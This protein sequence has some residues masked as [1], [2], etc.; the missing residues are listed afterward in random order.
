MHLQQVAEALGLLKNPEEPSVVQADPRHLPEV[1]VFPVQIAMGAAVRSDAAAEVT[2]EASP[3]AIH[4]EVFPVVV[5]LEVLRAAAF[6][7]AVVG[8]AATGAAEAVDNIGSVKRK[9]GSLGP[10]FLFLGGWKT[11]KCSK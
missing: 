6:Q 10:L 1:A 11:R 7:A 8:E 9:R 5:P 4:P 2:P 3:V